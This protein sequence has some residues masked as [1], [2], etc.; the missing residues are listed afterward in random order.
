MNFSNVN[1][2]AVFLAPLLGFVIGGLWYGP[3]FGKVWMR[4][5]GVTAEQTRAGNPAKKFGGVYLLN[6][7]AS[8]SLDMFI[9]PHATWQ[10]GLTAGVLA[11]LTF[12]SMALGVIYLFESR[13]LRLFLINASYQTLMFAGM[14]LILGAW[15]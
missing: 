14:G 1:W 2:F 12:V 8:F 3:L 7:V 15:R 9:G 6:L 5:A 4:A 10:F 11:G 13:P